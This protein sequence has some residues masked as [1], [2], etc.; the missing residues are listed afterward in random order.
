MIRINLYIKM[1]K[2][3][4]NK[5][6]LALFNSRSTIAIRSKDKDEVD[7]NTKEI[8][9][10]FKRGDRIRKIILLVNGEIEDKLNADIKTPEELDNIIISFL[11]NKISQKL[12]HEI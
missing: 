3:I 7:L 4:S 6:V 1:L 8:K 10:L 9:S 12:V 11:N 5:C 2:K